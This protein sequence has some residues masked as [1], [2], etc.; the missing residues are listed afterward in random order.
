MRGLQRTIPTVAIAALLCAAG[1]LF[2]HRHLAKGEG[3]EQKTSEATTPFELF[4]AQ[5]VPI[6][7]RRCGNCHGVDSEV[8]AD[9][10][11]GNDDVHMLA[12][13]VEKSGRIA[14]PDFVKVAY[15]RCTGAGKGEYLLEPINLGAPAGAS[16]FVRAPL[17][18]ELSGYLHS[19][20]EVFSSQYDPDYRTLVTWIETERA[21]GA[22]AEEVLRG[23]AERFFAKKVMPILARKT[24]LGANCHGQFAFNDLKLDPGVPVL[25]SR[26]T[27]AIHKDNRRAMLGKVTRLV[28][29]GGDV[30]QSK[31]LLKNI[32]VSSGGMVHKGGNNFFVKGDP[33][34]KV[35]V[36]WLKLEARELK[37]KTGASL[38]EQ[39][40]LIFVRRARDSPER[41][42][43]SDTYY[44]GTQLV[45]KHD[46]RETVLSAALSPSGEADIRAPDVSYDAT[47]VAF[48]MRR[49]KEEPFNIWEIE[50]ATKT[51]RQLTFSQNTRHHFMEPLYVPD[52]DDHQGLD[53]SRMVLVM[54]SNHLGRWARSSPEAILGEAED[55]TR[56]EIIDDQLSESAGTYTGKTLVIVRGTNKGERRKIANQVKGRIQL[57]R[58]LPKPC[59]SST[60]YVI[61]TE[62]RMAPRYDGFRMR[63]AEPGKE[64]EAF[65]QTLTR[66]TYSVDQVRRP[67]IRSDGSPV[68]T[69][70]RTG[71]QQGRPYFNG[72]LFRLHVDGSE[73]HPHNGNRSGVPIHSD[74]R[75][76]P[77]GLEIRIGRDADS[78]WGGML[79]LSDH[80]FGITIEPD[81][82]LDDLDHP[83]ATGPPKNSVHRF[84]PGWITLD[85]KATFKG[86]S[87]GGAYRDPYPM[88][89]GSILVAHAPGTVDLADAGAAPNFDI[90]RL[91][92]DP[93]FQSED[94]FAAGSY[95][96]EVVVG[97]ARSELWP[98]PVVVRAKE[99]VEKKLKTE[100]SLFGPPEH[101]RG[102][103]RHAADTPA[104]TKIFDY[105]LLD[106]FF[107]QPAPMGSKRISLPLDPISGQATPEIDQVQF[108]R[109][110]A[111]LPQKATDRGPP[112]QSIIAEVPLASD[113]S[114]YIK[115]PSSSAFMLQ[116][117]NGQRMAL[118]N[119]GRW[120]YT[121]PGE[122]YSMSV[123]RTLFPQTCGGCHG[124][125]SGKPSD[126]FGHPDAFTSASRTIATWDTEHHRTLK[127]ANW[128]EPIALTT[129]AFDKDIHPILQAKCISCHRT[130][131]LGAE[132]DLAGSHAF[133]RLRKLVDHREALSS[134][135]YLIEKLAGNELHAPRKLTG[136]APHPSKELQDKKNLAG[137]ALTEEELLTFVRWVDLGAQSSSPGDD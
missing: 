101:R 14:S 110:V 34:Y 99:S 21:A 117:L 48:A 74:D 116:S 25:A 137:L 94:G 60:H 131:D 12:W 76:M 39:R 64:R 36:E 136:D 44:R 92:A 33:D 133:E 27:P 80:Q 62:Q 82:P 30:E 43:E 56:T 69:F 78:Y 67:S 118:R 29:L 120:F 115:A 47:R 123:P 108:V 2:V 8:F 65:E 114:L 125:L 122:K 22:I 41:F 32:A 7:D 100:A 109:L 84:V 40:G 20:P 31:Q 98:R 105:H 91:V 1:A 107:E 26:Y 16:P 71:W 73:F 51:A 112:S 5:V 59:D 10:V 70:L 90:F 106:A 11:A 75:E 77:S 96:R 127:P 17:A 3:Q 58:P 135:S 79:M 35:L 121:H 126:T 88:P 72:A 54:T 61:E 119:S 18:A 68:F 46:G 97:G 83:Y 132:L 4:E 128:D 103:V 9:L 63:L 130:E 89:D 45:W 15:A 86:V 38:G 66:M 52:P 37:E 24:C 93:A 57:A 13:P 111:G 134:R 104:V 50:L 85:A 113:G 81:N 129:V 23:D 19:H 95:R 49:S 42:L 53:L 55:G 28:H 6:L 102:F 124:S 87:R